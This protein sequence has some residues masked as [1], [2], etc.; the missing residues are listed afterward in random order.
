MQGV[1]LEVK[2][3]DSFALEQLKQINCK[4]TRD[5]DNLKERLRQKEEE[6]L[7]EIKQNESHT[8]QIN[9]EPYHCSHIGL[10]A[11]L[12]TNLQLKEK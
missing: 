12:E 2:S 1:Q 8:S 5:N 11:Q 7:L 9:F 10:I 3:Q 6:T 4:L